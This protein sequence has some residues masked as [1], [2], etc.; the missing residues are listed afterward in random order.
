[1]IYSKKETKTLLNMSKYGGAFVR[2]LAETFLRA[3]RYNFNKLKNTFSEYWD[4]YEK[5]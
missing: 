1:M 5:M 3:N 2:S 4:E